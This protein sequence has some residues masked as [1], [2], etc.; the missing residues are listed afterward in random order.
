MGPSVISGSVVQFN[1]FLNSYYAS[2]VVGPDGT[3]DGPQMWLNAAF[4]LIQLPLGL[5]GVVI[6]TVTLPAISRLA[7]EGITEAF[8]D[9]IARSLKL[10]FLMTLPSAVGMAFL[11]EEIIGLIYQHGRYNSYDTMQAALALRMYSWGLICYAGIKIVQPAFYAIDRRYIPV[12]ISIASVL[13][14]AVANYFAVYRWHLGHE[15]LALGT[16]LSA[17]VN[18]GLLMLAM[19]SI[20]K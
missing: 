7:T 6:G 8:K 1:L 20:A 12:V 15:Y 19:R 17:L 5:F 2:D 18:F 3:S 16:S 11:A 14:S 9:T 10:V 4:R 13:V